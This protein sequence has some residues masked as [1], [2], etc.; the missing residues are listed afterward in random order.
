MHAALSMP[1]DERRERHVALKAKVFRTTAS[2][3]CQRF[4]D[5]LHAPP[6]KLQA[7]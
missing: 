7:A 4:L 3:Y 1:L 5:A 2:T 6:L